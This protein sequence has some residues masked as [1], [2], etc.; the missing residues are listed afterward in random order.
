MSLKSVEPV[1]VNVNETTLI[2]E[3]VE[4]EVF[5]P[6]SGSSESW[7][8]ELDDARLV[9]LSA[10]SGYIETEIHPRA[11]PEVEFV[12]VA[13]SAPLKTVEPAR[14]LLSVQPVVQSYSTSTSTLSFTWVEVG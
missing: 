3:S 13:T 8:F 2:S 9:D 14:F 5:N 12:S 10:Q 7:S 11:S 6:E 4:S 1:S